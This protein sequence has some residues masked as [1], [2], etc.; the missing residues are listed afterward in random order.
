M[1]RRREGAWGAIVLGASQKPGFLSRSSRAPGVSSSRVNER[2]WR[3]LR[4][5]NKEEQRGHLSSHARA[6]PSWQACSRSQN[7]GVGAGYSFLPNVMP[8]NYSNSA[9]KSLMSREAGHVFLN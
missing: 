9:F 4:E 3:V 2:G 5:A 7:R 1:K 6:G 8:S